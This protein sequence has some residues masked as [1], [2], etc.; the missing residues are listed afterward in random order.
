MT[1]AMAENPPPLYTC[2][3]ICIYRVQTV[4]PL[5][6]SVIYVSVTILCPPS[7]GVKR[8]GALSHAGY[9]SGPAGRDGSGTHAVPA[10]S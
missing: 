1:R 2:I 7:R 10:A 6:A 5:C 3:C 8:R 4:G 9:G